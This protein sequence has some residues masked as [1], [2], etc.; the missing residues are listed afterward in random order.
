METPVAPAFLSAMFS[1]TPTVVESGEFFIHVGTHGVFLGSLCFC[2]TDSVT[3]RDI[4]DDSAVETA[5]KR[6]G[7][8]KFYSISTHVRQH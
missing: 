4:A 1:Q 2:F 6:V 8:S 3:F 5:A 7:H